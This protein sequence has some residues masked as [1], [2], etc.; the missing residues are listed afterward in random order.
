MDKENVVYIKK[1]SSAI[2]KKAI[3]P[4]ETWMEFKGIMPSEISQR[5]TN[6]V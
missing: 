1:W 3:L 5:K 4:R 2:K 6:T